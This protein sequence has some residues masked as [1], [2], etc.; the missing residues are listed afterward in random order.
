[1]H[2]TI[3]G[4]CILRKNGAE[5]YLKPDELEAMG[6]SAL[7]LM[8]VKRQRL[9]NENP[10]GLSTRGAIVFTNVEPWS[11]Y[12]CPYCGATALECGSCSAELPWNEK[13][14]R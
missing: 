9:A 8:V 4:V 10:A 13:V 6:A 2:V 14:E 11:K 3:G 7:A 5:L 1:M 12:A